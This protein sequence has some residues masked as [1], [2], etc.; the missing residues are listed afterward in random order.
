M[1]TNETLYHK[2][3]ITG[4]PQPIGL[5]WLDDSM[6]M[7]GPTEES[8]YYIADTG[9]SPEEIAEQVF[10]YRESMYQ[11][12]K[13]VV[14]MG[15]F[16]WQLM[17]GGGMQVNEAP[18]AT[19]CKAALRK[20]C[21]G[22]NASATPTSWNRLQMYNV[23]NGGSGVTAQGFTDYTAE[24]LLTRGP[25]AMVGYSWCGCTN[26]AQMR[27]RAA[28]WDEDFGEPTNVCKETGSDSGVFVRDWSE[29]TVEWNCN[30]A[31]GAPRG[32]ISRK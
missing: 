14:P 12:T 19:A 9:A 17:D 10:A 16:W 30:A 25:Y 23:P 4:A 3:P 31:A 27:P 1:V 24:F 20:T 21:I 2:D 13:K 18:S 29:A 28:E 11:L 32:K 15:G 26:G 7:G 8:S 22:A 6:T 5:G